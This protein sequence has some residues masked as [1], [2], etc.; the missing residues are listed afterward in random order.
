MTLPG[1]RSVPDGAGT[2]VCR[3]LQHQGDPEPL[4]FRRLH[5][6]GELFAYPEVRAHG[7]DD[8]QQEE[9]RDQTG[10][11]TDFRK[12]SRGADRLLQL[13]NPDV[14]I[15]DRIAVILE[16]EWQLVGMCTIR[17]A[18]LMCC[19]SAQLEVVLN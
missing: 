9:A 7:N 6:L 5:E 19:G 3:A 10:P 17:R 18:S 14:S 15:A 8:A 1:Q 4:G 2:E 12:A 16:F 11:H 13:P